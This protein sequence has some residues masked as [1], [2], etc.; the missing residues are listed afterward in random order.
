MPSYAESSRAA[1]SPISLFGVKA[2]RAITHFI[3]NVNK[4]RKFQ[5][6]HKMK[7]AIKLVSRAKKTASPYELN[8]NPLEKL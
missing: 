5:F 7:I 6:Y 3:Q 1:P 4:S 8:G 2:C